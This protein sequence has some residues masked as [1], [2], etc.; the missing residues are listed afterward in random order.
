[1][2][3]MKAE[4]EEARNCAREEADFWSV[5]SRLDDVIQL[6]LALGYPVD[7]ATHLVEAALKSLTEHRYEANDF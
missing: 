3:T 2:Q 1:M 7:E 5:R 4:A 6:A